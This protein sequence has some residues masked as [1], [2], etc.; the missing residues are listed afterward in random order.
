MKLGNA[1]DEVR[2]S[3]VPHRPELKESRHVWLTNEE[4]LTCA[5]RQTPMPSGKCSALGAPHCYGAANS[6]CVRLCEIAP[7]SRRLPTPQDRAVK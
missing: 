3:E 4:N 7:F 5:Q 1:I 2:Q 6:E